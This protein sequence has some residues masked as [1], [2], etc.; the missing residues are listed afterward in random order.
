[1]GCRF[2]SHCHRLIPFRPS[3]GFDTP[4]GV[5]HLDTPCRA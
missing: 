2:R 4:G 3:V 5:E 1:L